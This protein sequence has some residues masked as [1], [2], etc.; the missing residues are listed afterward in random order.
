M[1]LSRFFILPGLQQCQ[2]QIKNIILGMF[3][4][5]KILVGITGSI[6]AY[7]TILLV[8]ELVK[9]GAEV[10]VV[11]TTAAKDFVSPLTLSTLSKNP[12]V[13]DLFEENSWA[14]HV[15]LGRW[16]DLFIIAPLSCNTIAK[17]A[18]GFCD[19]LLL[20]TYLSATCP[21]AA[22][23]A[24]DEDMWHHPATKTN[25]TT[26]ET[27]GVTIIP[28]EKGEL[29]SGLYGEG[30]MAEPAAIFSFI[31]QRFFLPA[32]LNNKTILVSAG[33]THE[34]LDPV[35]FISNHSSGKM[36]IAIADELASRGAMVNLVLGPSQVTT[37]H[38]NIIVHKVKTAEEMY[39]QCTALFDKADVAVMSAAVADYKPAGVAKEKIKKNGESML[40]EL[41]KT[42]DILQSLGDRKRK[43]QLLVGFALETTN[44]KEYALNKLLKKNADIIVLNS[45]NDD[46]AGFGHDTNKVTIF[47]KD[48][49]ELAYGQKSKQQV[50]R[51]IVDRIVKMLYA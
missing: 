8:R 13:I 36:G 38:K 9:A 46:G 1:L 5:K 33:P 42:K 10:K 32:D 24:M 41:V 45:L 26:I 29:A 15:M 4:G 43:G 21:V 47:E 3:Q 49:N 20:A 34:P 12:V 19:N 7:K 35:R 22:A 2:E 27:H 37:N 39:Q 30:R 6:A 18:H 44:E 28:V 25:L 17:M 16:A 40:L 23:P 11:M 51:D 50:A 31:E 14:N 48:G